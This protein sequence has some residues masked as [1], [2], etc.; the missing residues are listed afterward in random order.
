MLGEEVHGLIDAQLQQL[1]DIR[2]AV[3]DLEELL[4]EALA[5]AG[6]AGEVDIGHELHLDS[7]LTSALT[8]LAASAL[9]IEA[10]VIGLVAHLLRQ[11]EARVEVTDGIEGTD[12]GHGIGAGAAADVVLVHILHLLD[13]APV[14]RDG[15]ELELRHGLAS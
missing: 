8:G 1:G 13:L 6:L 12:V 15:R 14:A 3:L 2:P 7:D 4:A 5:A 9:L 10:E 11:G